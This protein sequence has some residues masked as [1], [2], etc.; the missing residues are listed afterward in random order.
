[1]T[2]GKSTTYEVVQS[3]NEDEGLYSTAD[4]KGKGSP[5]P[6]KRIIE[7]KDI[8]DG[9]TEEEKVKEKLEK[10]EQEQLE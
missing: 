3:D 1:M 6:T 2:F 5:R 7:E 10:E 9:R 8:S 4:V